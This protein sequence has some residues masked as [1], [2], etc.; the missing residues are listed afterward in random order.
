MER[1]RVDCLLRL[2]RTDVTQQNPPQQYVALLQSVVTIFK[3]KVRTVW[4]TAVQP[5]LTAETQS[6]ALVTHS[7]IYI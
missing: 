2:I 6:G 4:E 7:H 5:R 3:K 1:A